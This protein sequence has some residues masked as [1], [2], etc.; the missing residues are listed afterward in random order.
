MVAP[1]HVRLVHCDHVFHERIAFFAL[2]LIGSASADGVNLI[3]RAYWL[4]PAASFPRQR[5]KK[6][7]ASYLL[8]GARRLKTWPFHSTA[9]TPSLSRVST[10]API[11]DQ[12]KLAY[13]LKGR[14]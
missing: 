8:F 1:L 9:V 13:S 6:M 7:A 11:E 4:L 12:S 10:V 14:W 2:S 3:S 5:E